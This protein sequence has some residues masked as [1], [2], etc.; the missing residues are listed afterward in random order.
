MNPGITREKSQIDYFY[1]INSSVH[2]N[3]VDEVYNNI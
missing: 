2:N 1:I 3:K